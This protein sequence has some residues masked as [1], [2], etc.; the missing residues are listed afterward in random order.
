M[1]VGRAVNA[2]LGLFVGLL[3]LSYYHATIM[4]LAHS[5]DLV[6]SETTTSTPE[7]GLSS[8]ALAAAIAVPIIVVALAIVIFFLVRYFR[9]RRSGFG[10]YNPNKLEATSG[11]GDGK[12]TPNSGLWVPPQERLF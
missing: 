4:G 3:L 5:H 1:V 10:S 8:G 6:V 9:K 11:Q 2:K 12:N 7:T